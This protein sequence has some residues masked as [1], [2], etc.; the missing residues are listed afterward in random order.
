MKTVW[1]INEYAGAPKYGMEFRHYYIGRELVRR[2]YNVW[3]ISASHSHL[4]YS[5]PKVEESFQIEQIDGIN[6]LWVKVPYYSNSIDKRRGL[7]WLIFTL[8]VYQFLP[9]PVLDKPDTIIVSP[10][11]TFP[12]IAAYKWAKRFNAQLIYEIRDIWPLT[13]IELGGYSPNHPIIKLM[14]WCERFGYKKADR[15]VSLLPLAYFHMEKKGLELEKFIYIPN[16]TCMD[17]Y[18][19]LEKNFNSVQSNL[20][21]EAKKFKIQLDSI[22]SKIEDKFTIIYGGSFGTSNGLEYL[23]LAME[24]L[25]KYS[26]IHLLLVGKGAMEDKL[27]RMVSQKGLTNITF[28]PSVPK[29]ILLPL[30]RKADVCYIGLKRKNL[31]R[32]GIS[33]NKLFDYLY[34]EKPVIWAIDA[35]FNPVESAN[36]GISV[37]PDNPEAIANG[38][39][40]IY[41]LPSKER[42]QMGVNGKKYLLQYHTY[43]KIVDLFESIF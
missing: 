9:Y 18:S 39:L 24:L 33:P 7:K 20:L 8:K 30:L 17:E 40:N 36:C 31:F 28:I 2:G 4:F 37:E 23:I 14:D 11:A 13:L 26:Q 25:K 43:K 35:G 34:V 3:I 12:I 6:Y 1:I 32:F 15:V 10:M 21:E 27:K 29:R 19:Q 38:I 16:G 5:S 22:L 42:Y 41:N